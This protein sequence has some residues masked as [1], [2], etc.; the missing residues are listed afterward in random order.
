MEGSKK[1]MNPKRIFQVFNTKKLVIIGDDSK[2]KDSA[3]IPPSYDIHSVHHH[4]LQFFPIVFQHQQL[5][6]L[7]AF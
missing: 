3:F 1:G 7:K 6:L 4:P 2:K 5:L